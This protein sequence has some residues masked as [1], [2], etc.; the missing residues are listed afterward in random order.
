M[1][2]FTTRTVDK[3]RVQQV[4]TQGD[5]EEGEYGPGKIEGDEVECPRASDHCYA[6]WREDS[7]PNNTGGVIYIAQGK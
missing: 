7:S 5:N 3:L 6:F 4:V 1:C 2:H